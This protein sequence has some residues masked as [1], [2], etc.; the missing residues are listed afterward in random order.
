MN[1]FLNCNSY[2]DKVMK[3]KIKMTQFAGLKI[4]SKPFIGF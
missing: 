4:N 2:H 1:D 3:L